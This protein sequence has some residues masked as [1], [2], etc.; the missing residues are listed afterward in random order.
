MR[1]A[2]GRVVLIDLLVALLRVEE[3]IGAEGPAVLDRAVHDALASAA[4]SASRNRLINQPKGERASWEEVGRSN[5]DTA[6]AH[7]HRHLLDKHNNILA[8]T[9]KGAEDK[10]GQHWGIDGHGS[11]RRE[12]AQATQE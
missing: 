11:D 12:Q 4:A 5:T 2:Y 1:R 9:S 8:I 6:T 3:A 7:R 10:N